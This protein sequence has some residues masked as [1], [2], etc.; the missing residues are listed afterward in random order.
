[1]PGLPTCCGGFYSVVSFQPPRTALPTSPQRGSVLYLRERVFCMDTQVTDAVQ[2]RS[3]GPE[4][5]R[6]LT[7]ALQVFLATRPALT[8]VVLVGDV[9][10]GAST[11]THRAAKACMDDVEHLLLTCLR[12]SDRVVRCGEARCAAILLDA[13]EGGAARAVERFQCAL[14]CWT[15]LSV[16]LRV[17]IA[18]APGR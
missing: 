11:E 1:M 12:R 4:C 8:L 3:T 10:D 17:G 18:T 15:P 13:D 9:A 6:A 16:A 5:D 2:H 7:E 14:G